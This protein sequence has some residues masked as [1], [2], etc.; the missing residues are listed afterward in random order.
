M[1]GRSDDEARTTSGIRLFLTCSSDHYLSELHQPSSRAVSAA[2]LKVKGKSC[3]RYSMRLIAV[4]AAGLYSTSRIS[5]LQASGW[6][7]ET[8]KRDVANDVEAEEETPRSNP[9]RV[10]NDVKNLQPQATLDTCKSVFDRAVVDFQRLESLRA[11]LIDEIGR[12][13]EISAIAIETCDQLSEACSH[14][15]SVV[16]TFGEHRLSL[17]LDRVP[18][19]DCSRL[20]KKV[21]SELFGKASGTRT[22]NSLRW[23]RP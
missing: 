20:V 7:M 14:F 18:P 19:D 9:V 1:G 16:E 10:Q 15:E 2:P 5:D 22:M 23:R 21:P 3:F 8:E 11:G 13:S 6:R 12:A 4:R 17:S